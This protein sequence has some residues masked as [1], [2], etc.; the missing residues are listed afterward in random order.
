MKL[1]R[2]LKFV[3][4]SILILFM[5]FSHSI[6]AYAVTQ[7]DLNN[8]KAQQ[9]QAQAAANQKAAEAAQ[10]KGQIAI[11]NNQINETQSALNQTNGSIAS[12]QTTIDDLTSQI[13]TQETKL[14][15]EKNKLN[16]VI[17]SWY[18]EGSVGF[19]ETLFSSDSLSSM[20][21]K[22]QY[23][24]SIK[25]QV[26]STIAKVN[27]LKAQLAAQK[28]D[29]QKKIADLQSLQQQQSAYKSS[30]VGQ[31]NLQSQMLNMTQTQQQQYL[32]LV[33]KYQTQINQ[34]QAQLKTLKSKSSWGTQII[35][36][37]G[38]SWYYSQTGNWTLLGGSPFYVN[39]YGCLVTSIAMVATFYGHSVT[40]TD[41]AT[42]YGRFDEEGNYYG[43]KSSIGVSV[44][45]SQSI[46]WSVVDSKISANH[47]VI[48]GVLMPG[49]TFRNR[50]GS[51]HY[52][53]I[54]GRSGSAYLMADP[55]GS[56]RGYNMDQIVSMKIVTP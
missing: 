53:V 27:D 3:V 26:T 48:I 41:M 20:V 13:T 52:I 4:C 29:Q 25:L 34:I 46:D 15:D 51:S 9:Q 6:F 35:S 22:Q 11:V 55:I 17:S 33:A 49:A 14:T 30:I 39:D 44:A 56:G 40:P 1:F 54:Y 16:Q 42:T 36:G 5:I 8:A 23:Y 32:A 7:Q 45:D 31:R 43:L 21:S 2:N 50:D 37:G 47:P 10:M 19:F 28:D 12:T 24:D 18:M 38:I